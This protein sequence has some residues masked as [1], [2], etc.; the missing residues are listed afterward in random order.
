MRITAIKLTDKELAS[1][2]CS[3]TVNKDINVNLHKL[4]L[5]EHSPI[6]T[7][8]FWIEMF[9]IPTFVSV[10]F[11]RHK[12]GVEHFVKSNREDKPSY[13]GD[14]GRWHP[15]NHAML[16]NAQA[17][18]SMARKR[19]CKRAHPE[20]RKIMEAIKE[21]IAACDPDLPPCLLP[22]CEYRKNCYEI[23][24]CGYWREKMELEGVNI[25]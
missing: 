23:I 18:I 15:V 24:S 6:R 22:D 17:L 16:I 3:F 1:K 19:L 10:H 8:I 13:T 7:Q 5:A 21:T 9:D 20:T 4:Y 14:R 2:A 12:V 11:V 25:K